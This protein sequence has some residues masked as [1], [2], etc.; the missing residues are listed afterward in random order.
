[1]E[2]RCQH[3]KLTTSSHLEALHD[4]MP[5]IERTARST[6]QGAPEP[7]APEES[8]KVVVLVGSDEILAI[9]RV[10]GRLTSRWTNN[11]TT[12]HQAAADARYW[13]SMNQEG[14]HCPAGTV[15][16]NQRPGLHLLKH[17]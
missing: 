3:A 12:K 4:C 11:N 2:P 9:C 5:R 7:T 16:E 8:S 6:P 10:G 14:G 17:A 15:A 1:V 13:N